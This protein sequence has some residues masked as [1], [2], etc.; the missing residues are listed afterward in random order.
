MIGIDAGN[1][2]DRPPTG[3]AI[4]AR[5]LTAE[6]AR[7]HPEQPFAWYCRSNRYLRLRQADLPANVRRGLLEG[8]ALVWSGRRLR[9]FHG[10]NQ[11]LPGRLHAPMV[12]TFHDLFALTGAYATP[13]FR[14]RFARLAR[15]AIAR[16][17]HVIAVS[18]H[19]AGLVSEWLGFPR[20]AI[21]VVH[22]GVEELEV[23]GPA[24]RRRVLH[25]LGITM[26][27]VLHIGALQVRKNVERIVAAFEAA[28][29]GCQLVLAGPS[30]YGAEA[31][32]A[33][34]RRSSAVS[35]IRV[36]G[37]VAAD[38]RAAL[39]AEAEVLLFPSLEEGFGLPVIEA[40]AAGLPV[41]ASD[42]SA[43]PEVAGDAGVLVNP[44]ETDA[45]AGALE[46]VLRSPEL[47]AELARKGK[48]R[49]ER[50]SWRRCAEETWAVYQ[51]LLG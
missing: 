12:A 11:R 13:E 16:A 43:L 24:A 44:L 6:L 51:R 48:E 42:V 39:Y 34:V 23:P 8:F 7:G 33:R 4:Y 36:P 37:H 35:R 41:I 14:G 49:A 2:L 26:P 17:D 46:R 9:L 40:F 50:F 21:T 1:S 29:D 18:G 30:G 3:V 47:R 22:H 10:L 28:G 27:Y 25:G 32:L 5:N 31:I 38:A 15:E 19:T 45:I 20:S